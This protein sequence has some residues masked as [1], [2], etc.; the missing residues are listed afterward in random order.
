MGF[1]NPGFLW[2]ALGGLIPVIIH[3]L[4][5]Q[6]FRRV[7]WAAMEF[8]LAALQRTRRRL[9]MENLLLLLLRILAL[10][11]LSL[12]VA[13]PFFREAPLGALADSDT[14]H[15]FVV[16]VSGSMAYKRAQNS[17]LDVAR[18]AAE[19]ILEEIR[20]SEQDRFSLITLSSYPETPLKGLNRREQMRAG[21]AELRPSDYGTSVHATA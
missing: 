15:I 10:V 12:A 20:P 2:F 8:L 7:R 21:L 14:H 1:F 6:K 18:R 16:D 19:K 11:L 4:H 13:R 9:Q 17:S 5:R 3:L